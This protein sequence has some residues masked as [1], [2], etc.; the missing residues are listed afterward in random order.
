VAAAYLVTIYKDP[1][2]SNLDYLTAFAAGAGG[3]FAA[4]WTLLPWYS[5]YKAPKAAK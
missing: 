5:V 1:W 2:G 4:S 3:T